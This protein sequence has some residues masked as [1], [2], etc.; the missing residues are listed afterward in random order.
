MSASSGAERRAAGRPR[1]V[2]RGDGQRE[3]R[4][5]VDRLDRRVRPERDDRAGVAASDRS[6]SRASRRGRPR[7]AAPSR[8]SDP[9]WTGWTRPR[10]RPRANRGTVVGVEQLDV[11]EPRASNGGPAGGRLERVE[12]R[13]APPRRRSRGS[14]SRCRPGRRALGELARPRRVGDPDAAL[15]ARAGAAGPARARYGSSSAA[16][17]DPSVPS[18]KQLQPAEPGPTE[19]VGAERRRRSAAR[20]RAPSSSCSVAERGDGRGSA[21]SPRSSRRAVGG[22]T[23]SPRPDPGATSRPGR[24]RRRRPSARARG[25]T[26][27]IAASRPS[28]VAG[29]MWPMTSRA[30][31]SWR[32]PVGS[33]SASRRMMPPAG[34]A[35]VASMPAIGERRRGSPRARGDRGPRARRGGPA[36][37][38]RGRRRSA[39]RPSGRR[40]SR[41]PRARRRERPARVGG[42][43]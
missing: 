10:S 31:A 22:D 8:A 30:A 33:P 13:P 18:A 5:R 11:L 32:M 29:G 27:T 38:A 36:R 39:S 3:P 21:G 25:A 6:G 1:R 16:V 14:G 28:A 2:A 42:A 7:A 4:P 19:R 15:G 35:R 23:P 37:R 41:G 34:S 26:A 20:R 40:P 17:R 43:R 12:R 9:R 24:E